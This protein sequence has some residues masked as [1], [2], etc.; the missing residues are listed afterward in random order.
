MERT[1]E[2]VG[3]KIGAELEQGSDCTQWHCWGLILLA[4]DRLKKAEVS[5]VVNNQGRK[6]CC[7]GVLFK[8]EARTSLTEIGRRCPTERV[9]DIHSS[10]LAPYWPRALNPLVKK[11]DILSS[12]LASDGVTGRGISPPSCLSSVLFSTL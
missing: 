4:G 10:G 12:R 2:A 9:H 3:T 5:R 1:E 8:R 11:G 6:L 7:T